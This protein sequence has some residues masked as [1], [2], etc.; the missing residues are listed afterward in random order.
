MEKMESSYTVGGN[1]NW[2]STLK[3]S[4]EVPQKTE[5]RVAI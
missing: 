3:N 5:K 4:M 2:C 1:V